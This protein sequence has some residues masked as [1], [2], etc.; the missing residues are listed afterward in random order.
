MNRDNCCD[1]ISTFLHKNAVFKHFQ[2]V[3]A[4]VLSLR[5]N[6][7][8]YKKTPLIS[9][10]EHTQKKSREKNAAPTVSLLSVKSLQRFYREKNINE[11]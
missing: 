9:H 2:A 3:Y 1:R 11:F 7:L 4:I 10:V 8:L 5:C 6:R